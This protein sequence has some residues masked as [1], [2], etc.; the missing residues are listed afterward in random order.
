MLESYSHS[1]H[2]MMKTVGASA[3]RKK[4]RATDSFGSSKSVV[5][6]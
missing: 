6:T 5:L 2:S 3:L 4:F 1:R